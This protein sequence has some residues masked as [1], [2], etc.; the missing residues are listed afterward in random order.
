METKLSIETSLTNQ[1]RWDYL[2]RS[3]RSLRRDFTQEHKR[4]SRWFDGYSNSAYKGVDP[5]PPRTLIEKHQTQSLSHTGRAWL[6]I[7]S[8]GKNAR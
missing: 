1:N 8:Y 2:S 7:R 4:R 3:T 5:Q 6:K